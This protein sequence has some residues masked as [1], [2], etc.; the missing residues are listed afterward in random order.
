MSKAERDA[1]NTLNQ[2]QQSKKKRQRNRDGPST[3]YYED[4][5]RIDL[6]YTTL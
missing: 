4:E 5:D 6:D 2:L 3:F 1:N